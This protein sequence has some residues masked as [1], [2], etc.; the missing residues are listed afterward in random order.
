[1]LLGEARQ[2]HGF[3]DGGVT[4]LSCFGVH[5][6]TRVVI[7]SSTAARHDRLRALEGI[8][9]AIRGADAARTWSSRCGSATSRGDVMGRAHAARLQRSTAR[10]RPRE[11]LR[12]RHADGGQGVDTVRMACG[13]GL[14]DER[15]QSCLTRRTSWAPAA[16]TS[17][18]T[19]ST[20]AIGRRP[21][22]LSAVLRANSHADPA[23]ARGSRR[24]PGAAN[25]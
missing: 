24:R 5:P 22:T 1:M 19:S 17:A 2:D 15:A 14:G 3:D 7:A 20:S 6:H 16:S 25:S 12:V 13:E 8:D 10:D 11:R 21:A 23:R 4:R 18:T 9:W